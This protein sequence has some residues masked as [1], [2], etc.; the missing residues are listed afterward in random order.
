MGGKKQGLVRSDTIPWKLHLGQ[1][2]SP[3][4]QLGEGQPSGRRSALIST[5]TD[6]GAA[7]RLKVF[8]GLS[9]RFTSVAL[10]AWLAKV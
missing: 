10:Q 6:S 9:G 8:L 1:L 3:Q 5:L 2:D 7:L 4:M